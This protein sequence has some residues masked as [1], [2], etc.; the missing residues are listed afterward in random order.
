MGERATLSNMLRRLYRAALV[1][2]LSCGPSD[3]ALR[4]PATRPTTKSLTVG[5][6][7]CWVEPKWM[8]PGPTDC[9][10]YFEPAPGVPKCTSTKRQTEAPSRTVWSTG[11]DYEPGLTAKVRKSE[12]LACCYRCVDK[13]HDL[14]E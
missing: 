10:G 11:Y 1:L 14:G 3:V 13:L 6:S 2:V 8:Y 9:H 12:P 7:V 5:E 4:E